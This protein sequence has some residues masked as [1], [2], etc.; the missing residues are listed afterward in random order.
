MLFIVLEDENWEEMWLESIDKRWPDDNIIW[1]MMDI[2]I[3][4]IFCIDIISISMSNCI[5]MH[6][7][8]LNNFKILNLTLIYKM[9]ILYKLS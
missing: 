4:S 9:K 6:N 7:F 3:I 1:N 2:I 5:L 8:N